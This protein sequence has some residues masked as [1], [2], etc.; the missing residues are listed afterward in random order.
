M[1][2]LSAALGA[3][4][5]LVAGTAQ[6][7]RIEGVE[8]SDQLSLGSETLTLRGTALLRYKLLFRGYVAA[9][10]L[11]ADAPTSRVL[12]DAPR[13][14]EIEYFWSI[15][16]DAFQTATLEGIEKNVD[17]ETWSRLRP[18]IDRF[19]TFYATVQP[20]DRYQL[21]Y[22]PGTGTELALNGERRG[23]VEGA[24]FAR[25]LFSIWL[26]ARPFDESLKAQLLGRE[27]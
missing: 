22:L 1:K 4:L 12:G 26:G 19:N 10:Y 17:P 21:T 24:D 14:L 20:G 25:A 16:A 6:S 23:L 13:R 8:F 18:K 9:L 15:P 5:L 3:A 2:N 27:G 11:P 7:A